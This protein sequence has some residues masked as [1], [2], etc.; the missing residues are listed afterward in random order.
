MRLVA[1]LACASTVMLSAPARADVDLTGD[2]EIFTYIE[3]I[4]ETVDATVTQVG[5]SL[6]ITTPVDG[7]LTGTIDP[8]TGVFSVGGFNPSCTG[9]QINA[10]A[11]ADGNSFSGE[12]GR[13][14]FNTDP[15]GCYTFFGTAF[16]ARKACGNGLQGSSE[17]CDDGNT[18]DGD[19]CSSTCDARAPAGFVCRPAV[20]ACDDVEVCNGFGAE[21]P[22]DSHSSDYDGDGRCAAIDGCESGPVAIKSRLQTGT[23]DATAGNDSLRLSGTFILAPPISIDPVTHG[24]RVTLTDDNGATLDVTVPGGAF[25]PVT[26]TGWKDN[27]R[28]TRRFSSRT[29]VGGAITRLSLRVPPS[30]PSELRFKVSGKGGT[31]ASSPVDLPL[32]AALG[33]DDDAFCGESRFP[34]PPGVSP[35]CAMKPGTTIIVCK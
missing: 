5:S 29:P 19:C 17:V 18:D 30:Q 27:G 20:D 11:A 32:Y 23:Y 2:W 15:F 8:G 14:F 25:D 3:G 13:Q 24:V 35:G 1:V 6:T 10:T 12:A 34:G 4:F 26:R 9:F 28:G 16:G 21:C 33:F 7:P 31:Y 22:S